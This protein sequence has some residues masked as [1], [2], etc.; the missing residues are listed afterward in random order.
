MSPSSNSYPGQRHGIDFALRSALAGGIAGGIVCIA[1]F[2]LFHFCVLND[3]IFDVGENGCCAIGTRQNSLSN[4][5]CGI[6]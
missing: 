5:E 3:V 6:S 2:S 4:A 1:L